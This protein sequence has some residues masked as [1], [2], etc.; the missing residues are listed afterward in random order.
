MLYVGAREIAG[1]DDHEGYV[2]GRYRN[3]TYSDI[4]TDVRHGVE[5]TFTAYVP[6][7]ECGWLGAA[8]QPD[9]RG[10][11]AARTEWFH[12]HFLPFA[13]TVGVT[14]VRFEDVLQP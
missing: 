9:G 7:C 14:H 10:L 5:G 2:A 3:G 4:W 11:V 1:S 8:H 13:T 6:A 12:L